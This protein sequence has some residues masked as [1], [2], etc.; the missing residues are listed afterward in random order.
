MKSAIESAFRLNV[1]SSAHDDRCGAPATQMYS[2]GLFPPAYQP[3]ANTSKAQEYCRWHKGS[4]VYIRLACYRR[5]LTSGKGPTIPCHM[6]E[7]AT[8]YPSAQPVPLF[9]PQ[10]YYPRQQPS[11]PFKINGPRRDVSHLNPRLTILAPARCGSCGSRVLLHQRR[12]FIW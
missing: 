10:H 4:R 6:M 2:V 5:S 7:T 11:P 12:T 3:S 1:R 8:L 9:L